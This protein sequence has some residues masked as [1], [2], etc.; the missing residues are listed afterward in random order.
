MLDRLQRSVPDSHSLNFLPIPVSRGVQK[1]PRRVRFRKLQDVTLG[2]LEAEVMAILWNGAES[3][4]GDVSRCLPRNRAYTTVMTTMVRLYR[5]GLLQRRYHLRKYL[6]C[7][8]VTP[9]EWGKIVATESARQFLAT[10]N[11]SREVL[12]SSFLEAL[13]QH[14]RALLSLATKTMRQMLQERRR[15]TAKARPPAAAPAGSTA[16]SGSAADR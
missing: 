14:D 12:I 10:P 3:S 9:E 6:Y 8:R 7:A 1:D 15:V 5:K 4:V 16:P 2:P 11:V 13:F